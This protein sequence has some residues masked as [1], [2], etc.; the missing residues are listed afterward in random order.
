MR[1]YITGDQ[2]QC[3]VFVRLCAFLIR[4]VRVFV[5]V[6]CARLPVACM[7]IYMLSGGVVD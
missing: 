2:N 1:L 7:V 6:L 5:R 4:H 3:A